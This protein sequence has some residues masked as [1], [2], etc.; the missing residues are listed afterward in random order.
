MTWDRG[1]PCGRSRHAILSAM[2]PESPVR[3]GLKSNNALVPLDAEIQGGRLTW[4]VGDHACVQI[5]ILALQINVDLASCWTQRSLLL[6]NFYH[7]KR[8]GIV[9]TCKRT[10]FLKTLQQQLLNL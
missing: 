7:K 10:C 2:G 6:L 4:A 5:A 9:K 8:S 1:G 3:L